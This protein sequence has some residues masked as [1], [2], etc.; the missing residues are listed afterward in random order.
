NQSARHGIESWKD[1]DHGLRHGVED[2]VE[3]QKDQKEHHGQNNLQALFCTLLEFVLTRPLIGVT[4][5]Q[6][7][8]LPKQ[9]AGLAYESSVVGR[10]EI[11]IDITREL[12]IFVADH[13]RLPRKRNLGHFSNR[14][15]YAGGRSD[16]H[17]AEVFYIF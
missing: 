1:E 17:A 13:R 15:L 2:H 10:I 3:K 4:R 8:L 16:Q 7:Q 14:Y 6:F 5:W 12:A 9:V 11:D